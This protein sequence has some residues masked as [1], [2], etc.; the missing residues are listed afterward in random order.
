VA[1]WPNPVY[2]YHTN[3]QS[4]DTLQETMTCSAWTT[5]TAAIASIFSTLL[6][7]DTVG[8]MMKDRRHCT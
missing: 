4:H 1:S 2:Y 8:A 7:A 5:N 3:E 6:V